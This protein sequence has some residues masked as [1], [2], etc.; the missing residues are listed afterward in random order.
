MPVAFIY[1]VYQSSGKG[2]KSDFNSV[3]DSCVQ[4]QY[5]PKFPI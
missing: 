4:P 3:G 2:V 5:P 1:H